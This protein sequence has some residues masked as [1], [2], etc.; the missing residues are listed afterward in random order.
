MRITYYCFTDESNCL[1]NCDFQVGVWWGQGECRLNQAIGLEQFCCSNSSNNLGSKAM[2]FLRPRAKS[3]EGLL[4]LGLP[5][6]VLSHLAKY[7]VWSEFSC[8]T[9]IIWTTHSV[10]PSK[11][12]G[13]C[14]GKWRVWKKTKK[15]QR[16][17][18]WKI[19]KQRK[20]NQCHV[21]PF[22]QH[23]MFHPEKS[24]GHVLANERP[25][26]ECSRKRSAAWKVLTELEKLVASHCS[27]GGDLKFN[28]NFKL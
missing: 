20:N 27:H 12:D 6:G 18:A 13:P 23:T 10:S 11:F 4:D 19:C 14:V 1:E 22:G 28:F 17:T 21:R 16:N 7:S 15:R 24:A 3:H 9:E 2:S 5:F 8:D 26:E 25:R